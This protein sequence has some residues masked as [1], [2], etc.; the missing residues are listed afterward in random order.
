[1]AES[2]CAPLNSWNL[3]DRHIQMVRN[4]DKERSLDAH[5]FQMKSDAETRAQND[6]C[7]EQQS[8]LPAISLAL[9]MSQFDELIFDSHPKVCH[10][11]PH[12]SREVGRNYEMINDRDCDYHNGAEDKFRISHSQ[13]ISSSILGETPSSSVLSSSSSGTNEW[14]NV[15]AFP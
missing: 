12:S 13:G 6:K 14:L 5:D 4:K 9:P 3:Q 8:G 15:R 1:M 2:F 10:Q 7:A 11:T